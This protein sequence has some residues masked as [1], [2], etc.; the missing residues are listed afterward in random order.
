VQVEVQRVVQDLYLA[1]VNTKEGS[2]CLD[3]G[4]VEGFE[5]GGEAERGKFAETVH[6]IGYI[7]RLIVAYYGY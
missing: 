4:L 1:G 3:A 6:L 5:V 7:I 2:L